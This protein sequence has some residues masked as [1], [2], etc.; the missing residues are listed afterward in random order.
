MDDPSTGLSEF[1]MCPRDIFVLDRGFRDI[2]PY[3]E[4]KGFKVLMPTLKGN[5][6]QLTCQEANESRYVTKIR[7]PVEA[8]HG[9][10]KQKNKLLDN[11]INN[12][13]LPKTGSL[14]RI[15]S[16]LLNVFGKRLTSDATTTEEVHNRFHNMRNIGNTLEN[17]VEKNG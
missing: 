11:V 14:Y 5:R 13:I 3:L 9:M 10:I 15:A 2:V 12:K 6:K 7:W 8:V 16:Y 1:I 4:T 17:K